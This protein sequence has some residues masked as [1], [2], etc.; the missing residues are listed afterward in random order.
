MSLKKKLADAVETAVLGKSERER[1]EI[2]RQADEALR[3]ANQ[4]GGK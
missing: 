1:Q 4:K 3:D 2:E